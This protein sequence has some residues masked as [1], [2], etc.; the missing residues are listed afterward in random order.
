MN[1]YHP[2]AADIIEQ[3]RQLLTVLEQQRHAFVQADVCL[4]RHLPL[5]V[6]LEA[7]QLASQHA[8]AAWRLALARRWEY[9]IQARRVSKAI[10]KELLEF[11]GSRSTPEM[12]LLSSDSSESHNTP[13]E[14][15]RDIRRLQ[16]ILSIS[17]GFSAQRQ[18]HNEL[19]HISTLLEDAIRQTT[20]CETQRRT[21]MLSRRLAEEMYQRL[22]CSTRNTLLEKHGF[23]IVEMPEFTTL[24]A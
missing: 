10:Y 18:R 17:I 5:H 20:E 22:W 24:Q 12:L 19:E 9:E 8:L 3:S 15:L 23:D 4:E 13:H 1:I 14:I 16:A 11:Y 21:A 2:P 6:E 7:A